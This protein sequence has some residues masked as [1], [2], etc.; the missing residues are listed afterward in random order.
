MLYD[1]TF[2]ESFIKQFGHENK[3]LA[4]KEGRNSSTGL[5]AWFVSNCNSF[6]GRKQFVEKL[7]K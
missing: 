2:I 4:F 3:H 1:V 5:A 6:S 7:R